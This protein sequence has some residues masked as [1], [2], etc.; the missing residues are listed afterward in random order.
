MTNPLVRNERRKLQGNFFNALAI[1]AM[2]GGG[3]QNF[4][5]GNLL[6]LIGFALA[7]LIFHQ[8]VLHALRGMEEDNGGGA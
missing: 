7:G 1:G 6:A 4:S 2:V 5:D 8:F 3:I